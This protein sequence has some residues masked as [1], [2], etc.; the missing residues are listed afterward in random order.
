MP[1]FE[2]KHGFL[3]GS[4]EKSGKFTEI[5]GVMV[6]CIEEPGCSTPKESIFSTI[7]FSDKGYFV[8]FCSWTKKFAFE[9]PWFLLN[10]P[11]SKNSLM[12]GICYHATKDLW[13]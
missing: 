6:K 4:M 12:T 13:F 11:I 8:D 2:K 1:K 9:L 7:T 3:V 5:P 10:G